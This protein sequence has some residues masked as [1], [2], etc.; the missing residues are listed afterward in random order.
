[1]M[2]IR[3]LE[4]T[5]GEFRSIFDYSRWGR[6]VCEA[7]DASSLVL[8]NPAPEIPNQS[9][10]FPFPFKH[11]LSSSIL[12]FPSSHRVF[13]LTVPFQVSLNRPFHSS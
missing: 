10:T 5:V 1:V 7:F 9:G 8:G 11:F 3:L 4:D 6:W 2:K 13:P 12:I